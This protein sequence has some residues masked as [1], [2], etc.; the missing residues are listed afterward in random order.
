MKR[1]R[2]HFL[3]RTAMLAGAATFSLPRR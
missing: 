3:T 1:S 2:R